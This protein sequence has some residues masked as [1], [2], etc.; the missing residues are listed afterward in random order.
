MTGDLEHPNIVP[1]Y[2]LGVDE[3][4]ALFYSMKRVKGTPWDSVLAKKTFQENL[5][6]LMK[7]ADATAPRSF[8]R[9]GASRPLPENV[10]LGDF[11]EVLLMDWGLAVPLGRVEQESAWPERPP[12]GSRKWP[13][14]CEP[15]LHRQRR[16]SAGSHSL[17]GDYGQS[18]AHG[19]GRMHCLFAAGRNEIRPRTRPG[20]WCPSP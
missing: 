13:V 14:A 16:V 12:T 3:T 10:M 9:R 1:I 7:V 2:D 19:Q 20:N 8:A 6:I 17:R 5:E 11:G 4:G 15:H 18:A